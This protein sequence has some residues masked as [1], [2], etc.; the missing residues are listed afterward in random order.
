[1]SALE[2][3]PVNVRV[4]ISALWTAILFVFAYVDL[5]SLYRADV[6]ADI[7]AGQI[8]GFT[9]GQS[10]LLATT[11]YIVVPALMVVLSVVLPARIARIVNL[12]L[13]VG[14]A[15]TIV[16]SSVGEGYHYYLF[17][18]AVEVVLLAGIAFY[19]WTWPKLP[20]AGPADPADA[21]RRQH[22]AL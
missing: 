1:M 14:Y 3:A 13:A 20:V 12:V 5:F 2:P 16:G 4:K 8:S 21:G 22:T 6:R 9:I 19:A 17:G 18:S 7:E 15:L 10:F 11:A